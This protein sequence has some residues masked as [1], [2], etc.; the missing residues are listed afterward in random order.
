MHYFLIALIL[1]AIIYFQVKKYRDTI[2]KLNDFQQI[3]PENVEN[4]FVVEKNPVQIVEKSY[5]EYLRKKKEKEELSQEVTKWQSQIQTVTSRYLDS[6]IPPSQM[7]KINDLRTKVQQAQQRLSNLTFELS[8]VPKEN[9]VD[10]WYTIQKSINRY[11]KNN[12]GSVSDFQLIKDIV[13][14]NCN[15]DEEE[16]QTQIPVPLYLGLVGTMG[17]IVVGLGTLW[18]SGGIKALLSAGSASASDGIT[19]L[20]S[21]VALA[22]ICSIVGILLTTYGSLKVKDAKT[23]VEKRKHEFLS[24]MQSELLPKLSQGMASTLESMTRNLKVFND[25][26]SKNSSDF[27]EVLSEVKEATVGQSETLKAVNELKVTRI[28][29]ANV[30]V[31]EKLKGCT[32]ELGQFSVYL[33]SLNE[34][35]GQMREYTSKLS[36]F[37]NRVRMI[38]EM[39]EFFKK[40]RGN[41]EKMNGLINNT[42]TS[43]ETHLM[44]VVD[45]FKLNSSSQ[46]EE[47]V[48]H[49]LEQ[50]EKIQR[51]I[52]EQD[53]ALKTKVKELSELT[54]ELKNLSSIKSSMS[55]LD[56]STREQSAV[57]RSLVKSI[58]ELMNVQL[59]GKR[60]G[61]SFMSFFRNIPLS[62]KVA[63]C[64]VS[65]LIFF[66]IV[67]MII[68]GLYIIFVL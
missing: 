9:Y 48:K 41:F 51:V 67:S 6:E 46:F 65:A 44:D 17:G 49:L 68:V 21:G 59:T 12:Q 57:M 35:L 39:A 43:T 22:M 38:E 60:S 15:A 7:T 19:A 4:S 31:Y 66:A 33:S 42:I 29:K 3:F 16:I 10:T 54:S 55:N 26:F 2:H 13:D 37:D 58:E 45:S 20:L 30:E 47:I 14:R 64:S 24:W 36:D 25:D 61:N 23:Q 63:I 27:R 8:N 62:W 34:Y 11:L 28:A 56:K 18:L 40:E 52:E 5:L 50:R 1:G 53:G 32:D